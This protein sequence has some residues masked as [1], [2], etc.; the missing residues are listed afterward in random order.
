[1]IYDKIYD[2]TTCLGLDYEEGSYY[3]GTLIL[4]LPTLEIQIQE[5]GS[6]NTLDYYDNLELCDTVE[7]VSL[8]DMQDIILNRMGVLL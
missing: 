2:F 4:D 3:D 8:K 7:N 1:M 6:V 5:N